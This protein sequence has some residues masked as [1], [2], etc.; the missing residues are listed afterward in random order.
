MQSSKA[1][2]VPRV[3][4]DPGTDSVP[5]PGLVAL[6]ASSMASSGPAEV[7][8]PGFPQDFACAHL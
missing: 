1:R 5:S 4:M 7:T 8:H 2:P 3:L 6:L